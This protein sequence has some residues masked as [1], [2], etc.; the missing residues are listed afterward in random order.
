MKPE[1][2]YSTG[3][4]Y[5]TRT[6]PPILIFQFL[7][8]WTNRNDLLKTRQDL[9]HDDA[10]DAVTRGIWARKQRGDKNTRENHFVDPSSTLEMPAFVDQGG[11][12]E[13]LAC[14]E[15][16]L[17]SEMR[18]EALR[19]VFV[20]RKLL[21]HSSG[22]QRSPVPVPTLCERTY[23]RKRTTPYALHVRAPHSSRR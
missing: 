18:A 16:L 8:D 19:Q 12:P 5:C 20:A 1:R 6:Y 10:T 23:A 15:A 22:A 7:P 14:L 11:R 9:H 21:A 4:L 13:L 17:A 3:S 2:S